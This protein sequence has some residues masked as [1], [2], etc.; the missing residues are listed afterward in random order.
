M[1]TILDPTNEKTP[2]APATDAASGAISRN[3]GVS[4]HFEAARRRV[5][6]LGSRSN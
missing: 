4:R 1:T 6:R 2:I 3:G 5:A